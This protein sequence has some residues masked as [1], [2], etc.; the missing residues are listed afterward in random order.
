MR[1][2]VCGLLSAR[3]C[4]LGTSA[5]WSSLPRSVLHHATADPAGGCF[6]ACFPASVARRP[7]ALGMPCHV[8]C[9]AAG[10]YRQICAAAKH[11][12]NLRQPPHKC[13]ALLPDPVTCLTPACH[14]FVLLSLQMGYGAQKTGPIPANSWLEFDVSAWLMYGWQTCSTV[15]AACIKLVC[16]DGSWQPVPATF[17]SLFVRPPCLY[18]LWRILA[19]LPVVS[20]SIQHSVVVKWPCPLHCM[21]VE[22]LDVK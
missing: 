1:M 20:R 16:A 13:C 7:A 10:M 17:S 8:G 19:L 22:L 15:L 5:S 11:V 2:G 4:A 9:R 14:T 3:A 12:G 6:T 21:Q 18:Q